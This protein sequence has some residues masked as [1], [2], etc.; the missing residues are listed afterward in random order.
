MS[1][2][3]LKHVEQA[4]KLKTEKS[5]ELFMDQ[6]FEESLAGYEEALFRAELLNNYHRETIRLGI[7][8]LQIF[9]ISC[10]NI[11]FT[12]EEMGLLN[13]GEKMLR[14]VIYFLLFHLKKIG[15]NG[16]EI[17]CELKMAMMNYRSYTTRNRISVKTTKKVFMD[18]QDQLSAKHYT[19]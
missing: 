6:R 19:F 3:C 12:C 5:N 4:W 13:K 18:I 11:V 10:N 7:P 8:L 16:D 9:A 15:A 14:R 17:Q 1:D 2:T